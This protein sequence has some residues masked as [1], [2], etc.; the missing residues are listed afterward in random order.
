MKFNPVCLIFFAVA[1][2]SGYLASGVTV[3][4][5]CLLGMMVFTLFATIIT[6]ARG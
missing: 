1:F 3:G 2:L 4:L 6:V 5:Y